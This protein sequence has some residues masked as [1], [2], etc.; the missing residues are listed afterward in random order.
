MVKTTK[1]DWDR[2]KVHVWCTIDSMPNYFQCSQCTLVE[3]TA[4]PVENIPGCPG[5]PTREI[6][7]MN[8]RYI[9][10]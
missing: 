5:Y 8:K 2:V 7:K 6:N 9:R 4:T 1:E 10:V 3:H